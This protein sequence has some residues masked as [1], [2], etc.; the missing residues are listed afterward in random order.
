[1]NKVNKFHLVD[2]SPWPILTSGAACGSVT[3]FALFMHGTPYSGLGFASF[4]FGLLLCMF[5]WWKDVIKEAIVDAAHTN[6]VKA[7]LRIGMIVFIL[8]EVMFF[9][10]FFWSFFKAWLDPAYII[11]EVWPIKKIPWPPEGIEQ[12]DAWNLPFLNTMIL[13]LSGTTVTWAHYCLLR[14]N[15]NGVAKA[16]AVTIFLGITFTFIQGYEY[17]HANFSM[18]EE[19]YKSIY[20]S[21]FYMATGFHGA[22]VIIGTIFLAVCLFRVLNRQLTPKDHLGFEFAAWYWHFVDVVWLFLF[23]FVYWIGG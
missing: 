8:S 20:S 5:F 18:Q 14:G 6:V 16:L 23:T 22:H 9:F 10:T 15:N 4:L 17:Y 19:G 12:L 7:G 13:L 3:A 21:N 2:P 11:G 1:M